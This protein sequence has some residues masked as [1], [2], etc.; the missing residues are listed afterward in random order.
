MHEG[1]LVRGKAPEQPCESHSMSQT[2]NAIA[3]KFYNADYALTQP[4]A[5]ASRKLGTTSKRTIALQHGVSAQICDDCSAAND[6]SE[7]MTARH[8]R[9]DEALYGQHAV[10]LLSKVLIKFSNITSVS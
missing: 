7:R 2:V 4:E 6:A 3:F 1:N 8:V 9:R 5:S 10:M